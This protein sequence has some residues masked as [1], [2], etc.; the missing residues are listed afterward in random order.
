MAGSANPL[1]QQ[2]INMMYLVLLALM[3]MN[4]S[5]EILKAFT[6]VGKGIEESNESIQAKNVDIMMAFEKA[7]K[8]D[9]A[10]T[11]P[12]YDLAKLTENKAEE[13]N[14]YLESVKEEIIDE[15]GGRDSDGEI[16]GEKDYDTPSRIIV[17]NQKGDELQKKI[18][19]A[20]SEFLDILK[21]S[22]MTKEQ[23]ADFEN[24]IPLNAKDPQNDRLK[25]NWYTLL[26]D[27]VPVPAALT[28]LTKMQGDLR[29]SESSILD[30]LSKRIGADDVSFDETIAIVQMPKTSL[31]VGE[32]VEAQIFLGAYSSTQNPT[33]TIDGKELEK[34]ES[35]RGTY[36][37][38][39]ERPGEYKIEGEI[40]VKNK[41]GV[42]EANPFII[43]YDVFDAP[44][45][46]SADKTKVIYRGL[47]NPITV[48]VPGFKPSQINASISGVP[49][50]SLSKIGAG[51][52]IAKVTGTPGRGQQFA[53]ITASVTTAE[54][55]NKTAG[56]DKFRVLP[57]PKP[58]PMISGKTSGDITPGAI[59]AA[60][61]VIAKMDDA[62]VFEGVKYRVAKFRFIY[63]PR[64]GDAKIYEGNGPN[65]TGPMNAAKANPQKGDLI[66]IDNIDV[67]GP[68]GRKRLTT[69][70]SLSVT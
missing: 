43:S 1:R 23:I 52:Y 56:S 12:Y 55:K 47:E 66:I 34:V 61:L 16:K 68:D 38:N 30:R 24:Q 51:E 10:K 50:V 44:A 26:F 5:A 54:G 15:S 35:G 28:L 48:S 7:L 27:G 70:I 62:F 67:I 29:N 39:A 13:L 21:K 53:T 42:M 3:A 17:K 41:Q 65:L 36:Q 20:R 14:K 9:E 64:V 31:S 60:N 32:Q 33:I 46:I 4:V 45:T 59:K 18:N 6:I 49:G 63:K 2:M 11:R 57:V 8:N 19:Q 37:I 22:G 58:Y 25:R 69:G 40:G